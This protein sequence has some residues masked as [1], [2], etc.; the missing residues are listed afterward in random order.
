MQVRVR[1]AQSFFR[2]SV[3]ANYD[4]RCTMCQIDNLKLLNAGHIIPWSEN[5]GRRAD[6]EN[7]LALCALRDRAFDRG[8]MTIDEDHRVVLSEKL[9]VKTDSVV[10]R[11]AFSDMEGVAITLPKKFG[12]AQD[13]LE[14]HRNNVF[15]N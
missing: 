12:P 3:L 11:A 5:E 4:Y 9:R 7:G 2:R 8:L 6:P 1:T 13:A 10:H 14:W 15:V